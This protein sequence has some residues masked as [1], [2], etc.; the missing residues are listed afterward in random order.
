V[1]AGWSASHGSKILHYMREFQK[2]GDTTRKHLELLATR[3]LDAK[4]GPRT[5]R[6]YLGALK[7]AFSIRTETS[8]NTLAVTW[9]LQIRSR[10]RILAKECITTPLKQA[11]AMGPAEMRKLAGQVSIPLPVRVIIKACWLTGCRVADMFRLSPSDVVEGK[12]AFRL[13]LLGTKGAAP[14]GRGHWR[15]L[16]KDLLGSEHRRFWRV[17]VPS[18]QTTRSQVERILKKHGWGLHSMRR[19]VATAAAARGV[20]MRLIRDILGHASIRTTRVYVDPSEK[21]HEATTVMLAI[22][23]AQC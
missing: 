17:T 16:Q 15:W 6:T 13:R 2:L 5:K 8:S 23:K 1:E 14:G 21:Q 11:R 10:L 19:G 20:P 18:T 9:P 22:R 7:T 3:V 4:L 12:R